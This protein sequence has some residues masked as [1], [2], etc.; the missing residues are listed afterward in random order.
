MCDDAIRCDACGHPHPWLLDASP[1]IASIDWTC[2]ECGAEHHSE[3][4]VDHPDATTEIEYHIG[5]PDAGYYTFRFAQIVY[6][7]LSPLPDGLP[8]VESV[9][10]WCK[11]VTVY[12]RDV[13]VVDSE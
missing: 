3:I 4:P 10:G 11:G 5:P 6:A 1:V 8:A 2:D 13:E 7:L 12:S 9:R